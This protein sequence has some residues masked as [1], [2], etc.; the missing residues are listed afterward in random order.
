MSAG[1]VAAVIG[2]AR[3]DRRGAVEKGEEAES[4]VISCSIRQRPSRCLKRCRYR[5]GTLSQTLP[6]SLG[7]PFASRGC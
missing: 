4:K 6:H 3:L 2:V 1:R 7:P 5:M